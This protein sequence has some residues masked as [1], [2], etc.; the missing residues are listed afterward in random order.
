[1]AQGSVLAPELFNIYLE[2]AIRSKPT[3]KAKYDA[4]TAVA[5]ADDL[6]IK[7]ENEEE[8]RR[9]IRELEALE[10]EWHLTLNKKKSVI[11]HP[12]S[13]ESVGGIACR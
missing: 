3:L 11:L 13:T 7:V 6:I 8:C 10:D 9:V 4:A 1:V 12:T 5:F 2:E